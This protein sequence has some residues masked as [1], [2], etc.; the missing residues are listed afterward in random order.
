MIDQP[1]LKA[2]P[3]GY[4]N[5]RFQITDGGVLLSANG[6]PTLFIQEAEKAKALAL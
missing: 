4:R 6:M 5:G 2:W 1:L 3:A